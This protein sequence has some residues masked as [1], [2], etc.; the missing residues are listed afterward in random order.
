MR[1]SERLRGKVDRRKDAPQTPKE[2]RKLILEDFGATDSSE[3]VILP[4]VRRGRPGRFLY[5]YGPLD[6]RVEHSLNDLVCVEDLR[7][8]T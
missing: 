3:S 2:R 4:E 1:L 5:L 8:P 6:R 7:N